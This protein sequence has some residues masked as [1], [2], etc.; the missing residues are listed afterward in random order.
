MNFTE[1]KSIFQQIAERIQDE[2][3]NG[4]HQPDSRIPSVRE[5]AAL[6]EVNANTV[7]RSY[8]LLQTQGIIYNKRGIGY[9]V[10]PD[11]ALTIRRLR[12]ENFL[13][14]EADYFF[15]RLRLL[16]ITAEE[17]ANMYQDY[18]KNNTPQS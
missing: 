15:S 1:S 9:F 3:L 16:N 6:V 14:S 8:D 17:L 2:I 18:L 11:A 5:Y 4:I 12:R 13:H 7:M 10:A